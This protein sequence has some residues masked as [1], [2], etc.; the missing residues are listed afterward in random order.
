M[1]SVSLLQNGFVVALILVIADVAA[2]HV[3]I[4]LCLLFLGQDLSVMSPA[5]AIVAAA[6]AALAAAAASLAAAA[7]ITVHHC[8]AVFA[9]P[10]TTLR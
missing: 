6:A 3:S 5:A 2:A 1:V 7:V 9:H 10:R 8:D 4:T